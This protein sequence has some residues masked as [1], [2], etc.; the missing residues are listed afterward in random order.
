MANEYADA[1]EFANDLRDTQIE[2]MRGAENGNIAQMENALNKPEGGWHF[3]EH[4]Q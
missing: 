1:M 4:I 3:M 2:F